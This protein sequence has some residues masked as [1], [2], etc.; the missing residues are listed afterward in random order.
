MKGRKY[1]FCLTDRCKLCNFF[2]SLSQSSGIEGSLGGPLYGCDTDQ[3]SWSICMA[4]SISRRAGAHGH[5]H[6]KKKIPLLM[7]EHKVKILLYFK[8]KT[9]T[10]SFPT[11]VLFCISETAWAPY[12]HPVLSPPVSLG[13]TEYSRCCV[14]IMWLE[15]VPAC[16]ICSCSR[17]LLYTCLPGSAGWAKCGRGGW[18]QLGE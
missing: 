2:F 16:Y 10:Y 3:V 15:R 8:K 12:S 9:T 13:K 17:A 18:S 6:I 5:Q 1:L 4:V 11:A 7:V 14:C